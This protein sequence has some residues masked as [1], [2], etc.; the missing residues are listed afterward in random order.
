[1]TEITEKMDVDMLTSELLISCC[2]VMLAMAIE[3][4]TGFGATILALPFVTMLLGLHVAVPLLCLISLTWSIVI[5][6]V[7]H[8]QIN[9]RVV[10]MVLIFAGIGL[11]FGFLI[12]A[13]LPERT[14]KIVLG[15][16]VTFSA[17]KSLLQKTP[18]AVT[19]MSWG[20][21][22]LMFLGGVIHGAYATGGPLMT[23]GI[24]KLLQNK[25][26]FRSSMAVIWLVFNAI[27]TT[28]NAIAGGV[29]TGEVL[30]CF[31]V[32]LPGMLVGAL[33][34]IWLHNRCSVRVFQVATNI[35]LLIAGISMLVTQ[36]FG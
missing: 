16:F 22:V 25:S 29:L 33:V 2:I 35:L 24:K 21:R 26:V 6:V 12:S 10:K 36:M 13:L 31:A 15:L 28:K 3:G 4:I 27:I 19:D 30:L 18:K 17:V 23:I 7:Y 34:G 1:M 20:D 8:Y 9:W 32:C 5:V 11:P 14:L